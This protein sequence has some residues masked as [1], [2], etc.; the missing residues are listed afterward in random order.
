MGLTLRKLL[1]A[2]R[3][4]AFHLAQLRAGIKPEPR[5]KRP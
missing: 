3:S 4:I 1:H 2:V 5:A